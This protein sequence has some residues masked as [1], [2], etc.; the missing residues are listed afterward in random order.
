MALPARWIRL[1]RPATRGAMMTACAGFARAQTAEA[2]PAALW[3]RLDDDGEDG[4]HV[5]AIV[6]P[7]KFVP[8]RSTRWRAWALAPLVA[9]YRQHGL[10]AYADAD[11][12]CLNGRPITGVEASDAGVCAVIVADFVPWSGGFM[13]ALRRRIEAQ[14]GWQ[15]DH[16]W[17]SAE[18]GGAIADAMALEATGAA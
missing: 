15:F 14:Y 4:R 3:A 16:S 1:G 6:A 12:I 17:P 8:G 10:C 5:F 2:P 7:L 11:R 9:A 18:E 13:E